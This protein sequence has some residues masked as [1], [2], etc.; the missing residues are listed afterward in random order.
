L[1]L[2]NRGS[3]VADEVIARRMFKVDGRD[4]ECRF[5]KPAEDRGSFFCRYQIDWP[6][7]SKVRGAGGVDAVQAILLAMMTA[8]TDLLAARNMGGRLV[9]WLDGQSL[10]LPVT[11]TMRDWDPDNNF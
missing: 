10:G 7:G 8:H 11:P 5:F 1:G 2:F 3:R 4:V 9:E 6:E